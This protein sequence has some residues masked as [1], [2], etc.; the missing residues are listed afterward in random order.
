MFMA[1]I[2]TIT[3]HNDGFSPPPG[4]K[5][6]RNTLPTAHCRLFFWL[7]TPDFFLL[8]QNTNCTERETM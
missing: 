7:L 4:M 8:F 3:A 6:G 1:C 5:M 2:F